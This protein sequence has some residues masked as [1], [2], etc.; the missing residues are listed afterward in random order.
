MYIVQVGAHAYTYVYACVNKNVSKK[1]VWNLFPL[2]QKSFRAFR[3]TIIHLLCLWFISLMLFLSF[4]PLSAILF[5]T[6]Q[7]LFLSSNKHRP[8]RPFM[9]VFSIFSIEWSSS[10]I[11][12]VETRAAPHNIAYP[13]TAWHRG[14][15][16]L[17][18]TGLNGNENNGTPLLLTPR[19][20][21]PRFG[22]T[23]E[24]GA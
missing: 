1:S 4:L 23:E 24:T 14:K 6:S 17:T 16:A 22:N 8:D 18:Q 15:A 13:H 7:R 3:D 11:H 21:H 2:G 19:R 12:K 9:R 10:H 5:D 20:L